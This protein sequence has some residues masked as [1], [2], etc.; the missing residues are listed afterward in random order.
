MCDSSHSQWQRLNA[1]VH[2][3]GTSD[4]FVFNAT[5]DNIG[6]NIISCMATGPGGDTIKTGRVYVADDYWTN[7]LYRSGD[8]DPIIWEKLAEMLFF[9]YLNL[10]TERWLSLFSSL[11]SICCFITAVVVVSIILIVRVSDLRKK[12]RKLV[13]RHTEEVIYDISRGVPLPPEKKT[14]I[15]LLHR[16][17]A[18]PG[19]R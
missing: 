19:S 11:I 5:R 18:L 1:T 7:I 17:H 3:S 2:F 13:A 6:D 9:T 14:K 10:M 16:E 15:T 8:T 4:W 12:K